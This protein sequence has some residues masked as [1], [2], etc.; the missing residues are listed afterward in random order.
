[1]KF[2][3]GNWL[4]PQ[5]LTL[6]H[7]IYVHQT[8]VRGAEVLIRA[9]SR[10]VRNRGD[11]LNVLVFTIRLFSPLAGVIGVEA[12][13]IGEPDHEPSLS[14]GTRNRL[15]RHIFANA[16]PASV[17][18][19]GRRDRGRKWKRDGNRSVVRQYA[20]PILPERPP[21]PTRPALTGTARPF[22]MPAPIR[23]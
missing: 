20:C 19:P 6:S 16:Q 9:P 2:S 10:D 21:L 11:Q 4:V 18:I 17:A 23:F 7:P 22:V 1:M 14:G 3:D 12:H 5:G 13:P 15:P 8:E